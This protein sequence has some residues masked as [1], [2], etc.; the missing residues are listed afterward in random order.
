MAKGDGQEK[1]HAPSE[2][3]LRLAAQRGDVVR[4]TDLPK[5]AAIILMTTIGLSA[6]ASIGANVSRAFSRAMALAGTGQMSVAA[7]LATL[8]LAEVAPLLALIAALSVVISILFGGWTFSVTALMPDLSKFSPAHGLGSLFSASGMSETLKSVVKFLVIGT[9]GGLSIYDNGQA[10]VALTASAPFAGSAMIALGLHILVAVCAAIGAV[11]AVDMGIQFWLHRHRHR[12]SD[13]EM[14]DEMKDAVGNPQVR[15]RQRAIARRIARARQ[16][17]RVPEASVVITNPTHVAVA[18]R[19]RRNVD[20]APILL[21]KGADMLA[22]EIIKKA[23]SFGIP[24]VEA[25]PLARAVYRH[26][27][28]DDHIPVALYRSCAEVLA[29]VWR[30]QLWRSSR[31]GRQRPMPPKLSPID[32]GPRSRA[33]DR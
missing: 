2:R 4:S 33:T 11:A 13:Q 20:A 12:M 19:F 22:V 21:A 7:D 8:V 15:Q 24:I 30:L 10:F 17:Q 18:I 16:M 32:I 14:R 28:P 23:R 29:Y 9:V 26:V 27:E 25:P 3:R 31:D 5:A 6:A 1:K